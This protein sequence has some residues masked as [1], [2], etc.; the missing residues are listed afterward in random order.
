M[1]EVSQCY[2]S[3]N[4]FHSLTNIVLLRRV[5]EK[6]DVLFGPIHQQ[7][8]EAL[9]NQKAQRVALLRTESKFDQPSRLKADF[10]KQ[11]TQ[12]AILAVLRK[13]AV[14][15]ARETRNAFLRRWRKPFEIGLVPLSAY[16]VST[17]GKWNQMALE[18]FPGPPHAVFFYWDV[19]HR[20]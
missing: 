13:P 5:I 15:V 20:K 16:R 2:E 8:A 9:M 3:L 1:L 12:N 11:V 6:L 17:N 7:A 4:Y 19:D 10:I 14:F 18:P